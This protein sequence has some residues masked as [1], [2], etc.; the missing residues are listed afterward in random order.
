MQGKRQF[1]DTAVHQSYHCPAVQWKAEWQWW[2]LPTWLPRW[3]LNHGDK[4]MDTLCQR[5]WNISP[6]DCRCADRFT[7]LINT[8]LSTTTTQVFHSSGVYSHVQTP[9]IFAVINCEHRCAVQQQVDQ[10]ASDLL[11]CFKVCFWNRFDPA[12][13]NLR[14]MTGI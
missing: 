3:P 2:P 6:L 9:L 4:V 5:M 12:A 8:V 7:S 13:Q 14:T 11:Q 10:W 1:W